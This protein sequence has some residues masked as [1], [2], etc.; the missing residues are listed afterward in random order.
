[1]ENY[2]YK[3]KFTLIY[4]DKNTTI[5]FPRNKLINNLYYEAGKIFN[6]KRR[7]RLF[8]KNKD[9]TPFLDLTLEKYFKNISHVNILIKESYINK[10]KKISYLIP[11]NTKYSLNDENNLKKNNNNNY[12]IYFNNYLCENCQKEKIKFFCRDCCLFICYKCRNNKISNHFSHKVINLYLE[13]LFKSCELYKQIVYNELKEVKNSKKEIKNIE[14]FDIDFNIKNLNEKINFLLNKITTIKLNLINLSEIEKNKE[15]N[16][17][18]IKENI[19]VLENIKEKNLNMIQEF[20]E[21]NKID[22][23]LNDIK[24]LPEQLNKYELI[25]VMLDNLLNKIQKEIFK[26]LFKVFDEKNN[27]H[28][29]ETIISRIDNYFKRNKFL[30]KNEKKNNNNQTFD[31]F[32]D[33]NENKEKKENEKIS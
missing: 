15:K 33:K 19:N 21:F 18:I 20:D 17:N 27:I 12:N 31:N 6:P 1:M 24:K 14:K 26:I 4:N 16:L 22:N 25:N 23:N 5:F 29:Y 32:D 28:E 10:N 13:N 7:Y 3:M 2:Y 30:L 8:Y 11:I 9:L